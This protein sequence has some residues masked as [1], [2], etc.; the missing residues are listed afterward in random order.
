MMAVFNFQTEY[1]V[2]QVYIDT[3]SDLTDIASKERRHVDD[4]LQLSLP[5][6][7]YRIYEV[8]R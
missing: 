1:R 2:L 7:G 4:T 5:P 3:P 8:T 6:F